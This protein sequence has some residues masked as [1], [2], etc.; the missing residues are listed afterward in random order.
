MN[1]E[2]KTKGVV[3][4][5][6]L[7]FANMLLQQFCYSTF[8]PVS[9]GWQSVAPAS[10]MSREQAEV[11]LRNISAL[12]AR[13]WKDKKAIEESSPAASEQDPRSGY[14]SKMSYHFRKGVVNNIEKYSKNI[15]EGKWKQ[16]KAMR[17]TKETVLPHW[18]TIGLSGIEI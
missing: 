3:L 5:E 2:C 1:S 11:C 4:M 18:M 16:A 10:P 14:G 12:H 9:S 6:D 8:H 7:R 15:M 17:L 13:F